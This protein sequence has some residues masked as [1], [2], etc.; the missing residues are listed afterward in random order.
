MI[1]KAKETPKKVKKTNIFKKLGT[2]IKDAFVNFHKRFSDGS[3]GT[4][5]SH[6][7][8]GAGNLYHKQYLKGF[9]FLGLQVLIILFMVL[10]PEINGT[11]YV[12]KALINLSFKN[13]TEGGVFDP[14]LGTL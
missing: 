4:K 9:M 11:P 5:L 1:I 7:V 14:A 13:V 3:I 12:Y 2:N 10:C 6:F 8:F